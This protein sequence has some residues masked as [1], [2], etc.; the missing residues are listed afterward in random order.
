MIKCIEP[1]LLDVVPV[2]EDS[3]GA[4]DGNDLKDV[5]PAIFRFLARGHL[6]GLVHLAPLIATCS[7]APVKAHRVAGFELLPAL[8]LVFSA[9]FE[10]AAQWDNIIRFVCGGRVVEVHE[11]TLIIKIEDEE[12]LDELR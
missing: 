3:E 9:H 1:L 5:D 8:L 12:S 7:C 6:D 4:L 10:Y 2:S 11:C